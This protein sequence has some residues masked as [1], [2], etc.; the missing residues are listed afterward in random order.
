MTHFKFFAIAGDIAH[1]AAWGVWVILSFTVLKL[2]EINP[3][4]QGAGLL[5]LYVPAAIVILLLA[6]DLI[7]IAGTENKVRIAWPNL[8]VKIISVLALCYSL[9]WLMAPALR[10]IW[11]VTE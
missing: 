4:A 5:H 7:R 10:Q 6:A 3:A 1:L 11:G 8:L 9:W 2:K